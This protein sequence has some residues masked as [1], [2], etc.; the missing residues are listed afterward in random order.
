MG[1]KTLPDL[2][3]RFEKDGPLAGYETGVRDYEIGTLD[4]FPLTPKSAVIG[5]CDM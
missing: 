1:P 5:A 2:F 4:E 3:G